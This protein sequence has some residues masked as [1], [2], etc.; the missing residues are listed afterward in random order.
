MG[1]LLSAMLVPY[2]DKEWIASLPPGIDVPI[3]ALIG[4]PLYVCATGSTPLAAILLAKGL[5]PG[6]VLALL[7]TGPATNLTTFGVLGRLHGKRTA[8]LFAAAMWVGT[9]A[10]G[11]LANLLLAGD[12]FAGP[13]LAHEHGEGVTVWLVL[14]AALFAWSLLRQGVR[15]FLERLFES[16]ANH[17]HSGHGP[18]HA[19][20]AHEPGEAG[21][22]HAHGGHAA[23][24]PAL[25]HSHGQLAPPPATNAPRS[26]QE[27][28]GDPGCCGH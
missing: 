20:C 28:S 14:L 18:D 22:H 16:P 25:L 19:C 3:A 24:Q 7:L 12:A 6:A 8:A 9:I 21:H 17:D 11:Y 26:P 4:L 5:S 13:S 2:V 1:L 23:V 15:P 10:L 27:H